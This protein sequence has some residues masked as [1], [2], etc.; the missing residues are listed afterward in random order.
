MIGYR[1]FHIALE[2]WAAIFSLIM[3]IIIRAGNRKLDKRTRLLFW[4]IVV[5]ILRLVGD[6]F[7]WLYRGDGNHIGYVMVVISNFVVFFLGYLMIWIYTA[8]EGEVVGKESLFKVWFWVIR[9]VCV[10]A[11]IGLV[12]SQ[13]NHMYYYFDEQNLYHRNNLFWLSQISG[14]FGIVGNA[15]VLFINRKKITRMDLWS[16]LC[17]LFLPFVATVVQLFFYGIALS[18]IAITISLLW[19]Y[20]SLAIENSRIQ[21]EQAKMLVNQENKMNEMQLKMVLSQIQPH[22]LYNA[23][24]SIYYLCEKDSKVAQEAISNFSDY[25]RVNLDSLQSNK[26]IPFEMELRHV[27]NYLALEKMRF[28]DELN[29]IYDIKTTSFCLPALS[30]QPLVENAVK[31]GVGKKTGGGTVTIRV[32]EEDEAYVLYVIDDGVGFDINQTKED[33]RTHIGIDNVRQRLWGMCKGELLIC[34]Q[35]GIGTTATIVLPKQI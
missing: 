17:Y 31:Y 16:L 1:I 19:M 29:I 32:V 26:L 9:I 13:Y 28:D 18:N 23:L 21:M 12:I 35:K 30:L 27:Q 25:L 34:A 20:A 24:N 8:Y 10:I 14:V 33:G 7:A 4:M 11:V 15:V 3:A 5:N 6:T 2:T 22:F